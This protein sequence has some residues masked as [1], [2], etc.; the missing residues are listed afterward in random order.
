M[1][2]ILIKV[3]RVEDRIRHRVIIL[4]AG[5]KHGRI[6]SG[7]AA[8]GGIYPYETAIPRSVY[9]LFPGLIYLDDGE[10]EPRSETKQKQHT[11][12]EVDQNNEASDDV[13]GGVPF[14]TIRNGM[15]T[16]T[17]Y[18]IFSILHGDLLLNRARR[19]PG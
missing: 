14:N 9:L 7:G 10:W 11:M 19:Q 16:N 8:G 2:A 4:M 18:R 6:T 13:P 17:T 5:R 1:S 15:R 3:V 12:S